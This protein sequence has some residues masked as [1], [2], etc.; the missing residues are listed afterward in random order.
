VNRVI[1]ADSDSDSDANTFNGDVPSQ[2]ITAPVADGGGG[3]VGDDDDSR[4]I[5]LPDSNKPGEW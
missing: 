4:D 2:V 1:L 3:D 5:D